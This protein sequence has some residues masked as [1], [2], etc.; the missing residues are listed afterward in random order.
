MG[1]YLSECI[2]D[3]AYSPFVHQICHG[4]VLIFSSLSLKLLEQE[5]V[6]VVS[7]FVV[8]SSLFRPA[9]LQLD[10]GWTPHM[11]GKGGVVL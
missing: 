7:F 1:V 5:I 8:L 9:K 2:P 6:V 11:S 3:P 10:T 4:V